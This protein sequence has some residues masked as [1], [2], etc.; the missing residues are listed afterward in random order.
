MTKRGLLFCLLNFKD[1]VQELG[2]IEKESRR[3]ANE[4]L[5]IFDKEGFREAQW[6]ESLAHD[7]IIFMFRARLDK[8]Y[9]RS[10]LLKAA[11][12][13]HRERCVL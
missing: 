5:L 12:R 1:K 6:R 4:A 10:R 13:G 7:A 11:Q 9:K 2:R 3:A 8:D